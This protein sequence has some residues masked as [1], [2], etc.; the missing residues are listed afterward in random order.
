MTK[1]S[2]AADRRTRSRL[3]NVVSVGGGGGVGVTS[4]QVFSYTAGLQTLVIPS[5]VTSVNISIYGAEGGLGANNKGT[6]PGKGGFSQGTLAVT[7]GETLNIYV[8]GQGGYNLGGVPGNGSAIKYGGG[9]S[10]V[11]QGGTALA[12]RVIVA[13]GGG[14]SLDWNAAITVG[15]GGD[16]GGGSSNGANGADG[17]V[18]NTFGY[19][20]TN[21]AGGAAASTYYNMAPGA[22]SLGQGGSS[23]GAMDGAVGGAGGGGYYGGGGGSV[24]IGGGYHAGGGGG[25]SGYIGGVTSGSGTSGTR[26]GNGTCTITW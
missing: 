21:S 12:N 3:A 8:G 4:P 23:G 19:A 6:I 26:S 22:G 1:V 10:D 17:G 14:A 20:G 11:R 9:A 5:G 24:S 25:G 16:G 18:G 13:G 7:P 15:N 2:T